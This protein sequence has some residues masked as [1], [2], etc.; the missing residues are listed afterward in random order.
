MILNKRRKRGIILV[1]T[2]FFMMLFFTLAFGVYTMSP[3]TDDRAAT[4]DKTLTEAHFACGSGLRMAKEWMSAVTK[5]PSGANKIDDLGHNWPN[6]TKTI[7]SLTFATTSDDVF[8]VP[9]D[10]ETFELVGLSTLQCPHGRFSGKTGLDFLGFRA[11]SNL[12]QADYDALKSRENSWPV[13][14]PKKGLMVGEYEVFTYLVPSPKAIDVATGKSGDGLKSFLAISI[15]YRSNLPILRSRCLFKEIS[16]ARNAYRSA[17]N[18]VGP[19]GFP[20]AWSVQNA[21]SVIFDGPVHFNGTPVISVPSSYWDAALTQYEPGRPKRGFM[22]PI[23][24]SGTNT[25][26]APNVDGAAW[27]GGNYNGSSS[28][29]RPFD[30]SGQAIA[31]AAQG[32]QPTPAD[33]RN[34]VDRYDRL[35][36]GGRQN[37]RKIPSVPLPADLLVL[38]NAAWGADSK[39]GLNTTGTDSSLWTVDATQRNGS[40]QTTTVVKPAYM[41]SLGQTVN[42][43]TYNNTASADNGIFVNPEAGTMKAAG[44]IAIK[45]DTKSMFLEVTDGNGKLVT[46]G[47]DSSTGADPKSSYTDKGNPTVRIQSTIDSYDQDSGTPITTFTQTGTSQGTYH[48]TQTVAEVPGVYK[49]TIPAQ[50]YDTV[51]GVYKPEVPG[52]Y[53][54][55]VPGVYKAEVPGVYKTTVNGVYHEPT[56]S[57]SGSGYWDPT[58]GASWNPATKPGSWTTATK[59]AS[60]NPATKQ[61]SWNPK[62]VN[63]GVTP[64]VG[65]SWNPKTVAGTVKAAYYDTGSAQYGTAG[66]VLDPFVYKAQ[67]WVVDVKNIPTK[68]QP[69]IPIPS[70]APTVPGADQ[71]AWQVGAGGKISANTNSSGQFVD[72]NGHQADVLGAD[73]A[74]EGISKVYVH[75]NSG[76]TAGTKLTSAMDVPTGKILVYKQSRS[77]SNRLDVFI[78]DN[79]KASQPIASGEHLKAGLN[80]AVFATGDISGLRGVNMESRSIGVDYANDK[81]IGIIDNVLQYGTVAGQKPVNAWHGLGLVGTKMNVQTKES[82][83]ANSSLYIYAT[84]VAGKNSGSGGLDVS[85][86]NSNLKTDFNRTANSTDA[87]AT[88]RTL[89]IFGGLTE[90]ITKARLTS[91]SGG[92]RGWNQKFSFDKQLSFN[93][94]PFFPKTNQL[95]PLAYFQEVVIGQ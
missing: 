54:A 67:D 78:L 39:T 89:Q 87:Q 66:T 64:T 2:L 26:L 63:A 14:K 49:D 90:Q 65:A 13:L 83:F 35:I 91:D 51:P 74:R 75:T 52:V 36:E 15:A 8:S 82:K 62:T 53:K 19:D 86:T 47:L 28:N 73:P 80:G 37:L 40:V 60:W 12:T 25:T 5:P 59:Q 93:P 71:A 41:N 88:S 38:K 43:S 6:G 17:Q 61:A 20:I 16:A 21:D 81:G 76:D 77:D 1:T 24:F 46:S 23:T 10:D 50:P 58:V 32:S 70:V 72:A 44:G 27:T 42:P 4:K 68:I 79:P 69:S 30:D 55:E 11:D 85:S 84:I 29:R 94:P 31:S 57:G 7:G 56:G 9:A 95:T 22:G 45:G 48:P 34:I 3:R 33:G 18:G 92:T